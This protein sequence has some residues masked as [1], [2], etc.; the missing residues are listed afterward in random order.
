MFRDLQDLHSFA[1][2]A[3]TLRGYWWSLD[4]RFTIVL[5]IDSSGFLLFGGLRDWLR[6]TV[7]SCSPG[8]MG[9]FMGVLLSDCDGIRL[10]AFSLCDLSSIIIIAGSAVMVWYF[11]PHGYFR[12]TVLN[13]QLHQHK[14]QCEFVLS[15]R[16]AY[17]VLRARQYLSC[18]WKSSCC[19]PF[20]RNHFPSGFLPGLFFHLGFQTFAPLKS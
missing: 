15:R 10:C 11:L 8:S 7:Y 20:R 12:W 9:G 18:V 5:L 2:F 3:T 13:S 6:D 17:F 16:S 1:P 19:S 14:I 4:Y